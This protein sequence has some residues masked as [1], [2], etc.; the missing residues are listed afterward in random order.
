MLHATGPRGGRTGTLGAPTT[1]MTCGSCAPGAASSSSAAPSTRSPGT[2]PHVVNGAILARCRELGAQAGPLGVPGRGTRRWPR[3][4]GERSAAS[5]T[6]PSTGRRRPVRGWCAARSHAL[7]RGRGGPAS[8]GFPIADDGGTADGTGALSCGCSGRRS[9]GRRPRVRGRSVARSGAGGALGTQDGHLRYPVTDEV[10]GLGP[11]G[12]LPG[13]PGRDDLLVTGYGRAVRRRSDQGPLGR[14]GCGGRA[15]GLSDDGRGV[16]SARWRLLP[17]LP[18]RHDLL[19]TG[20]GCPVRRWGAREPVERA[21][22]AE[23]LSGLSADGRGVR[24]G[25][26]GA[27]TRRSRAA[28][29]TGR[30][31]PVRGR[32]AVGIRGRWGGLGAQD[33]YLRLSDDGRDVRSAW[34]GLLPALPGR[35]DLL[36]A[37]LGSASG[38][39]RDRLRVGRPRPAR[40]AGSGLPGRW[41]P[42]LLALRAHVIQAFERG[43]FTW[44]ATTG[45]VRSS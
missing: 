8:L 23:R 29:S 2:G 20:V 36:V 9:T 11:R 43:S 28:R 15:S 4:A 16:R 17:E 19:V 31:P 34:W 22:C 32:P 1:A 39:R 45:Q 41:D 14:A 42:A 30:R 25:P 24:S 6:A 13:V 7:R 27:A 18:G 21:R 40:T 37:G 35:D 38:Q 44:V 5:R 12:L 33:G 10:C 26:R 3:A